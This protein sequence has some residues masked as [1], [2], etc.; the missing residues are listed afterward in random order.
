MRT[1]LLNRENISSKVKSVCQPQP[2]SFYRIY[3]VENDRGASIQLLQDGSLLNNDCNKMKNSFLI[4]FDQ[5][6]LPWAQWLPFTRISQDSSGPLVLNEMETKE[7]KSLF[8]KISLEL[9]TDYVFK[10]EYLVNILKIIILLMDKISQQ[11][12][13]A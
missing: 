12:A 2:C 5:C 8:E 3:F 10:N 4:S 6:A 13:G 11:H 9:N 7:F 1:R